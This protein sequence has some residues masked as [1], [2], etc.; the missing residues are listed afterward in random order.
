MSVDINSSNNNCEREEE[1]SNDIC[2]DD[3]GDDDSRD[4]HRNY[5]NISVTT[6]L[7]MT[8]AVMIM[9]IKKLIT[10]H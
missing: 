10:P 7:I 6:E 3:G 9:I 2:G 8:R 5:D 4:D 1:D